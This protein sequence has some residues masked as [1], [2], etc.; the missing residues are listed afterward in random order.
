M[1]AFGAW[2]GA[3]FPSTIQLVIE[4]AP[5]PL[6]GRVEKEQPAFFSGSEWVPR[7]FVVVE[8][9]RRLYLLED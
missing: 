9:S 1:Q 8:D 3:E 2:P 7:L 6:S 4:V 5:P